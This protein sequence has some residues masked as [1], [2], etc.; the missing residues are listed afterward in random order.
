[1]FIILVHRVR[2]AISSKGVRCLQYLDLLAS[3]QVGMLLVYGILLLNEKKI[4]IY[5]ICSSR[6]YILSLNDSYL[7]RL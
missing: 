3:I 5:L 7:G 1:M 4:R 6:L 2:G